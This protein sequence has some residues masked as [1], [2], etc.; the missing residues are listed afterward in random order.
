MPR[1]PK[2]PP[3]GRARETL[4]GRSMNAVEPP[5]GA[6]RA[7]GGA[8]LVDAVPPAENDARHIRRVYGAIGQTLRSMKLRP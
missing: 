7:R 2:N 3:H 6:V 1:P 5:A 8:G 4:D